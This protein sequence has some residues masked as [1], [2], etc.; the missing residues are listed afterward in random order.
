MV[1]TQ[2]L[3]IDDFLQAAQEVY[4]STI[5]EDRGLRDVVVETLFKHPAWLDENK[6][7]DVIEE[8]RGLAFDLL[9]Y[10]HRQNRSGLRF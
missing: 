2:S 1:A 10:T 9:M 8:L 4:T 7:Q 5:K 3:D 6:V